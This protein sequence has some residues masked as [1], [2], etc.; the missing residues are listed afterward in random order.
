MKNANLCK[1]PSN[2]KNMYIHAFDIE[3]QELGMKF[4]LL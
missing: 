1:E 2:E 3:H 4:N